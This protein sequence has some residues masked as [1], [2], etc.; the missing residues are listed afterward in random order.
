MTDKKDPIEPSGINIDN[1]NVEELTAYVN[2][3]EFD[4]NNLREDGAEFDTLDAYYHHA[5]KEFC[6][7]V[8][9]SIPKHW[10]GANEA[11]T[12]R[13]SCE[14]GQKALLKCANKLSK[15]KGKIILLDELDSG[16]EK[17]HTSLESWYAEALEDYIRL[18]SG[19]VPEKFSAYGEDGSRKAAINAYRSVRKELIEAL[20]L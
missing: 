15:P 7:M 3:K 2:D 10:L 12:E 14:A 6:K 5:I 18:M 9:M 8:S 11:E 4:P 1:M 13:M 19:Q 20:K 16:D 17:T